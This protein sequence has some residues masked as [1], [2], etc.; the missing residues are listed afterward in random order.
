V[1]VGPDPAFLANPGFKTLNQV[2]ISN[3]G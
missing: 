1:T 2:I 3:H